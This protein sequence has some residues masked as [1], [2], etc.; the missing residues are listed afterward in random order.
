MIVNSIVYNDNNIA[1]NIILGH[2]DFVLSLLQCQH[3][4][5]A[6]F[7]LLFIVIVHCSLSL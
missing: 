7:S 1:Y 6:L 3:V 4:V 2:C 5:L